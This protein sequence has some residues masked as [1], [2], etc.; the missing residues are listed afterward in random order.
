MKRFLFIS[1]FVVLICFI[2]AALI[3]CFRMKLPSLGLAGD[4]MGA[5]NT[6]F[7][8]LA[9]SAV[10]VAIILQQEQLKIQKTELNNTKDE[11]RNQRIA[12]EKSAEEAKK[13]NE[14]TILATYIGQLGQANDNMDRQ[15]IEL[16]NAPV[17]RP[18]DLPRIDKAKAIL[19]RLK[20]DNDKRA[21]G[22]VSIFA[23]EV[24]LI[25][26]KYKDI[27]EEENENQTT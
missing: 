26:D 16:K 24:Q 3:Y 4:A 10:V 7:S 23:K 9:L 11:L 25:L 1:L 5:L 6:L 12:Q 19:R 17:T 20:Q 13:L 21:Q 8:G 27:S 15:I 2:A 22:I 14:F 18:Q